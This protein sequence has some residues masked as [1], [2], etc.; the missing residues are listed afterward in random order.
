M[1]LLYQKVV[2]LNM[3]FPAETISFIKL[4][5]LIKNEFQGQ[6]A[7]NTNANQRVNLQD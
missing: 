1:E 3:S 4:H 5:K 7:I 2:V 6:Q